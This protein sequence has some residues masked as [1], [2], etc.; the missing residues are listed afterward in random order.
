MRLRQIILQGDRPIET[1]DRLL[2]LPQP[3]QRRRQIDVIAGYLGREGSGL[4]Q[5]IA[6]GGV[7][8]LVETDEAD[9]LPSVRILG[10]ER[11][12]RVAQGFR[13]V[14]LSRFPQRKR[15]PQRVLQGP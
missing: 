3:L 11:E 8:A 4:R 7:H 14:R 1:P 15:A 9:N 10:V 5:R 6:G 13:L 2:R 12:D